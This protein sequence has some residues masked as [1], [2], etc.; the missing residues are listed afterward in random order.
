MVLRIEHGRGG[1]DRYAMLSPQL[2]TILRGYWRLARPRHWL[3]PGRDGSKP[4]DPQV[5]H[6][7]CRSA[8]MAAG[9]GKRV[10]CTRCGTA[11]RQ[12]PPACCLLSRHPSPLPCRRTTSPVD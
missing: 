1:K 4:I 12:S 7:A 3:F 8:S 9:L 11:S 5:L 6:A 2:L 10:R